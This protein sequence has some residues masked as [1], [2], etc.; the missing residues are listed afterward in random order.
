MACDCGGSCRLTN[1]PTCDLVE[2]LMTREG[3]SQWL[4]R[5]DDQYAVRFVPH[6]VEG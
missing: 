1:I 5:H 2:E 3:V 4:V 6:T